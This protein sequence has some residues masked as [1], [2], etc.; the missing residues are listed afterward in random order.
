MIFCNIFKWEDKVSSTL[1]KVLQVYIVR[2][3]RFS[4]LIFSEILIIDFR[5][6]RNGNKRNII[7]LIQIERLFAAPP[8]PKTMADFW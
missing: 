5:S 6:S 2:M 8:F 7:F 3:M 1:G 4:N